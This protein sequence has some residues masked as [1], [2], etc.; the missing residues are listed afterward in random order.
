MRNFLE[1]HAMTD[2]AETEEQRENER[3][4]AAT[5]ARVEKMRREAMFQGCIDFSKPGAWSG[6]LRGSG[7]GAEDIF[8]HQEFSDH[9]P[10]DKIKLSTHLENAKLIREYRLKM[11]E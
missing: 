11:S 4:A 6:Y 1:Q 7:K 10:S 9:I 2:L 8:Q 5:L 3:L